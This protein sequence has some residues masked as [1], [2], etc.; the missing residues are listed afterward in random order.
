[1]KRIL[2]VFVL[3]IAHGGSDRVWRTFVGGTWPGPPMS[4]QGLPTQAVV[5]TSA[6]TFVID[7]TPYVAP[8]QVA[9][10]MKQAQDGAYDGTIFHTQPSAAWWMAWL[11]SRRS[12]RRRGTAKLP[13]HGS[14]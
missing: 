6:G 5:D 14:S 2:L 7:L 10:F 13:S 8:N 4:A 3:L 12:K 9:Y 1:M 11:S